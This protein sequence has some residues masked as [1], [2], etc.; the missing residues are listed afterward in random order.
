M[1][2]PKSM[3]ENCL[4]VK[5]HRKTTSI[6]QSIGQTRKVLI[7]Y[8]SNWIMDKVALEMICKNVYGAVRTLSGIQVVLVIAV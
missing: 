1:Q 2:C 3:I 6:V 8:L 7:C 5:R 4:A